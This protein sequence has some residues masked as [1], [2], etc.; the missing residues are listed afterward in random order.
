M[1]EQSTIQYVF[2]Y[3]SFAILML[4]LA[5][6]FIVITLIRYK[7]KK[8]KPIILLVISGIFVLAT[9]GFFI[10]GHFF[11]VES[12]KIDLNQAK[13]QARIAE[14]IKNNKKSLT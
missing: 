8:R 9:I 5:I 2:D 7:V 10:L 11:G 1:N 12:E 13:E 14:N 6:I 4:V 3:S